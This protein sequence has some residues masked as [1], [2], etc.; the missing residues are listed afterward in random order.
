MNR[1]VGE[2]RMELES[3]DAKLSMMREEMALII[4]LAKKQQSPR[5]SRSKT[6]AQS[7]ATS[8]SSSS[9]V[10]VEVTNFTHF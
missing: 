7:P 5:K 1:H 9:P 8:T 4:D 10:D 2:L 3:R 6:I